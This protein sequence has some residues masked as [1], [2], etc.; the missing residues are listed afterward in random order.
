M[1][2]STIDFNSIERAITYSLEALQHESEDLTNDLALEKLTSA[3]EE[4]KR[5]LSYSMSRING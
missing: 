3:Q 5:A 1:R 2:Y 4:L